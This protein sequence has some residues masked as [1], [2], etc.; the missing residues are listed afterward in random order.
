[1]AATVSI[2]NDNIILLNLTNNGIIELIK[3][4]IEEMSARNTLAKIKMNMAIQE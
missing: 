1:M 4:K 3:L 2:R